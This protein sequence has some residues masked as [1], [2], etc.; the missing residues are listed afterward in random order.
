MIIESQIGS[1]E[2]KIT[3]KKQLVMMLIIN[4]TEKHSCISECFR[5][6]I[7]CSNGV[8]KYV[9]ERMFDIHSNTF[10]VIVSGSRF[11]AISDRV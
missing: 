8:V 3:Q 1:L 9:I 6:L 7:S 4:G 5:F 11:R 2:P 10:C